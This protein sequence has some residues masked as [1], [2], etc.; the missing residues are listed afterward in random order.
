MVFDDLSFWFLFLFGTGF[1]LFA[2][3]FRTPIPNTI[4]D[5]PVDPLRPQR[6]VTAVLG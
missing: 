3:L 1:Q 4:A 2:R 6:S 5:Q